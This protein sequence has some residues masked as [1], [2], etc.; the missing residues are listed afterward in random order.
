M[1]MW[2][3]VRGS[4]T[5]IHLLLGCRG[6]KYGHEGERIQ[7]NDT[8]PW[9]IKLHRSQESLLDGKCGR[10]LS[11]GGTQYITKDTKDSSMSP[12]LT[13]TGYWHY[14]TAKE[15]ACYCSRVSCAQSCTHTT[16]GFLLPQQTLPCFYCKTRSG[17]KQ[18]S[19]Y[20]GLPE[21]LPPL[22]S[23]SWSGGNS[24]LFPHLP[25]SPE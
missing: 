9:G 7:P 3:K 24:D 23:S 13:S 12:L 18:S 1:G 20:L 15:A 10:R 14:T 19:S 6:T 2:A 4:G 25:G 21:Q 16:R 5:G 11:P 8:K 17:L 22:T